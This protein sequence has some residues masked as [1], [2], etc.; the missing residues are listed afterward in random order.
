MS[1][2]PKTFLVNSRRGISAIIGGTLCVC[3]L[4]K[5]DPPHPCSATAALKVTSDGL[6]LDAASVTAFTGVID[7]SSA[8]DACG[9]FNER[10]GGVELYI[11]PDRWQQTGHFNVL[12][13]YVTDPDAVGV[14]LVHIP[15]APQRSSQLPPD[16]IVAA[17]SGTVE[18]SEWSH[19][20]IVGRYDAVFPDGARAT[21]TFDTPFCNK[22][23]YCPAR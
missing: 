15:E 5:V 4:G 13:S 17:I 16:K 10:A 2:T 8:M 7:V 21:G 3:C 23:N 14:W 20:R 18:I 19:Q 11:L 9:R 22:A 1:R 12:K 6:S